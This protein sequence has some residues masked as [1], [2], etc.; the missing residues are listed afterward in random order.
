[1]TGDVAGAAVGALAPTI[2]GGAAWPSAV[3][4]GAVSSEAMS[5]S[6]SERTNKTSLRNK[7]M[8]ML[9]GPGGL[10]NT[11]R[12]LVRSHALA[13]QSRRQEVGTMAQRIDYAFFPGV[14]DEALWPT[15]NKVLG[16]VKRSELAMR[17][18]VV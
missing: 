3:S 9:S 13:L 7:P 4:A 10:T 14:R 8:R 12:Q 2:G 15:V 18:S 6:E 16:H 17:H 1:M 11:W 5:Q